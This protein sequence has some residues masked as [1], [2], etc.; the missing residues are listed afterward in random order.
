M[1]LEFGP[2]CP[3]FDAVLAGVEPVILGDESAKLFVFLIDREG[4][5]G[6]IG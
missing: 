3:R 4:G 5:R 1:R 2:K 6:C